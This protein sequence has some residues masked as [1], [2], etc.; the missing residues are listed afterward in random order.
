MQDSIQEQFSFS[1]IT[2]PFNVQH[3][4]CQPVYDDYIENIV[5]KTEEQDTFNSL[6]S[7]EMRSER[8]VENEEIKNQIFEEEVE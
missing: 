2:L 6:S 7:L 4:V 3:T 1:S 8:K 5:I